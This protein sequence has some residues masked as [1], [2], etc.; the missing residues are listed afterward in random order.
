M[1]AFELT[2]RLR[3]CEGSH[4]TI[5]VC[6]PGLCNTRLMRYTP[7]AQKPL[8]YLTAPF[9]TSYEKIWEFEIRLPGL[10][11][12]IYCSNLSLFVSTPL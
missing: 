5:N 4:V 11:N 12:K 2:R 8:N 10:H 9:S 1:H 7:L 3:A 6:H